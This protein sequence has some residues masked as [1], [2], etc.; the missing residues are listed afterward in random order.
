MVFKSFYFD[1][2]LLLFPKHS[3][4]MHRCNK[5]RDGRRVV[6][7]TISPKGRRRALLRRAGE[8]ETFWGLFKKYLFFIH[9]QFNTKSEIVNICRHE[10]YPRGRA[11]NLAIQGIVQGCYRSFQNLPTPFYGTFDDWGASYLFQE[12][13][14][15]IKMYPRTIQN[16]NNGLKVSPN[17]INLQ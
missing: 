1:T 17:S 13:Q 4:K 10:K 7:K 2:C 6:N 15:I 12:I 11:L 8:E 14:K 16:Q 5:R 9:I 3:R